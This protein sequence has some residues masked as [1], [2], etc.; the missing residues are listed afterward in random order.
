MCR[1]V[2]PVIYPN[3]IESDEASSSAMLEISKYN[4]YYIEDMRIWQVCLID[5]PFLLR[6]F[7]SNVFTL[8][9]DASKLMLVILLL[10]LLY[11]LSP[12]DLIPESVYGIYGLLDDTVVIIGVLMLTCY[13]TYSQVINRSRSRVEAQ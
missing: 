1:E 6:R 7:F 2:A 5:G 12:V 3:F 13:V 4:C 11:L 8:T 10:G 9:F